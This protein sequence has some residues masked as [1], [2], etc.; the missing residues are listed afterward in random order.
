MKTK[1]IAI[2]IAVLTVSFYSCEINEHIVPSGDITTQ[3]KYFSDYDAIDVSNAFTV[4]VNFS[5]TEEIIEIEA[6]DNLQPY[7][8]VRKVSGTLFI[9]LKNHVNIRGNAT[10]RVYITTKNVTDY[11]SSGA[12]SFIIQDK[13]SANTVNI[14]LSG[15]SYFSGDLEVNHAI[16]SLSGASNVEVEGNADSFDVSASGASNISNYDFILEDLDIQLS[17]ASNA[18]LTV[19]NEISVRASG[20][21]NL[22]YKGTGVVVSQNLSGA[23]HVIKVDQ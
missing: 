6:D 4:Y 14:H 23:S 16:A 22:Y 21:S 15:A 13:L 1:I 11:T 12:S 5:E 9:G 2:L 7:I 18:Y 3:V 17:G 20:A 19:N 10:L 8:E